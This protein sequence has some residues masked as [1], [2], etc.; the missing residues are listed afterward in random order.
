MPPF[1][2][3][4]IFSSSQPFRTVAAARRSSH[5]FVQQQRSLQRRL[6]RRLFC[7]IFSRLNSTH[8]AWLE[9]SRC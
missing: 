1:F 3:A 9:S 4:D 5:L 8:G 7:R 2:S 6:Q